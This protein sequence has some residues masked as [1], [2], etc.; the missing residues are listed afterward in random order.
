MEDQRKTDVKDRGSR[1]TRKQRGTN[2]QRD[3]KECEM[4]RRE[5]EE[6]DYTIHKVVKICD[7]GKEDS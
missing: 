1:V 3:G 7:F 5:L 2:E 4:T 6:L